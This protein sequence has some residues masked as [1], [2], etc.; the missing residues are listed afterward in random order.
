MP[1]PEEP[2][3]RDERREIDEALEPFKE[4]SCDSPLS[5]EFVSPRTSALLVSME[6]QVALEAREMSPWELH[7]AS[8]VPMEQ[9]QSILDGEYDMKDS[10][11][12]TLIER[13]LRWP[14]N[15]L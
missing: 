3:K 8:G 12:I 4:L 7:E 14:L 1:N 2:A 5:D 11:P 15:H 10:E 13:A 9:L 6:I